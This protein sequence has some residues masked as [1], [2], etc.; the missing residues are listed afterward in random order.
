MWAKKTLVGRRL[1]CPKNIRYRV[2]QGHGRPEKFLKFSHLKC[3]FVRLS[4]TFTKKFCCEEHKFY[5]ARMLQWKLPENVPFC[6]NWRAGT[7][8]PCFPALYAYDLHLLYDSGCQHNIKVNA[9]VQ[10]L[11][12]RRLVYSKFRHANNNSLL[13]IS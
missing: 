5:L 13:L 3:Y 9:V 11:Y 8:A 2:I 12:K 10:S 4:R 1:F 6:Q 7:V